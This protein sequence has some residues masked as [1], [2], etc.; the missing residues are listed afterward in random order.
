MRKGIAA[1]GNFI[2]DYVKIVDTFPKPTMLANILSQSRGSGGAPYNV[3][4]D[5]AELNKNIPL[6]AIGVCGDDDN[7]QYILED[8]QKNKIDCKY[9]TKKKGLSTSYTDVFTEKTGGRRTFFHARGANASLNADDILKA[10][11]NA[12]IFHLGYLLLLDSLDAP[13]SEYGVVA[14]RVLSKMREKGYKTS[15]DLVS[16]ESNRFREVVIPCLPYTDYLIINEIEASKCASEE[17]R[18]E[19]GGIDTKALVR[20]CKKLLEYGAKLVVVHFPEGAYAASKNYSS[21]TPSY[22]VDINEIIGSTGAGDA[23]CAGMLYALHEDYKIEEA[24]LFASASAALNLRASS[25][26]AAAPSFE[27]IIEFQ[28]RELRDDI[29]FDA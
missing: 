27:E 29:V 7:G 28:K 12:K 15:V 1:S 13:D 19:D 4:I 6:Y 17:V 24:L 22:K 26:T 9:V 8:L 10:E 25:S 21:F 11:T 2:V 5:L 14:A 20:A 18:L 3:L 16:E 23:F